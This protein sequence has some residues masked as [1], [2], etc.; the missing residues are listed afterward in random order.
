VLVTAAYF[1]ATFVG[2]KLKLKILGE[3]LLI[4]SGASSPF[5]RSASMRW[6]TASARFSPA[7]APL[8]PWNRLPIY[9]STCC[10]LGTLARISHGKIEKSCRFMA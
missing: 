6:P 7:P 5:R 3:K 10:S 9:N 2:Q 4:I 1:A 8:H